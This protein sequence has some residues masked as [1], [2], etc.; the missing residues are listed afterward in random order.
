MIEKDNFHFTGL[1]ISTLDDSFEIGMTDYV[2][3]LMDIQEIRKNKCLF[4]DIK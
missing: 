1:D 3:S 2:D 4:Y